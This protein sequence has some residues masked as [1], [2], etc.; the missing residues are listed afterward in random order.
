MKIFKT[1]SEK[2]IKK[3]MPTIEKIVHMDEATSKL[4][5]S[6]LRAKTL[7]FKN[8]YKLGESLEKLLPEAFAVVR[9]AAW[10]VLHMKHYPVQLI[11]GTVL[12]S[13]KIA[14][15]RTGEGKT[16]VST[17]PVYLNALT[18]LGVHVVTVN[19]YLAKRDSEWMGKVY[20]F[21]GLSVGLVVSGM[22]DDLRRAAYACDITYCT[23]T[24]LGFDYLRDNMVSNISLKV[25]RGFN[26]AIVDEIDSVLIDEARTPLIIS[27]F[28]DKT[29]VSY[30]KAND[31]FKTLNGIKIVDAGDEAQSTLTSIVEGN[32][33]PYAKYAE[34]DFVAE[35]KNHNA[36]LTDRG[37]KK[38]EDYYN[39]H[40]VSDPKYSEANFFVS[41]AL[42]A[43]TLYKKDVDYVINQDGE[44]VIVDLGTGRLMPG[45]RFSNGI[46]QGLEAKENV[47][48]RA[49]TVTLATIT[50]QNFFRKYPKLSGM[51]GTAMTEKD[52]FDSIYNLP[53]VE[54]PTNKPIQRVDMPD[55]VYSTNRAKLQAVVNEV[56][57]I[58]STG[59]P[60][61]IGTSSIE[62]SDELHKWLAREKIPHSILNAKH[63]EKEAEI[64]AQAGRYGAIT[65]S[66]NMAGRGTDIILGGNAE[67]M[68]LKFFRDNQYDPSLIAEMTEY[69]ETADENIL[70]ARAAF[71]NKVDE[72][73]ASLADETQ[74]VLSAGGLYVIGTERH[75]SRRIDNQLRG[76]SGR[77]GDVGTSVFFLSLEDDLMRLFGTERVAMIMKNNLPEN[78]PI[79]AK[80]ISTAIQIAQQN[81]ESS[82]FA[83]RRRTLEY[84]TV[85]AIVRDSIYK[86]RNEILTTDNFSG[87]YKS[88]CQKYVDWLFYSAENR[89]FISSDEC[90][91]VQEKLDRE[92]F[93]LV[94]FWREDKN[95]ADIPIEEM[96]N[97]CCNGL[98]DMIMN[99]LN[100]IRDGAADEI[101]VQRKIL[102]QITD[103]F[104][105]EQ[106]E[107]MDDIKSGSYLK[108]LAHGDAYLAYKQDVY[109]SFVEMQ[110]DVS[111]CIIKNFA[112]ILIGSCEK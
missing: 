52:E 85:N 66:T 107:I 12:H 14:E 48:I 34:Y 2:E 46:H 23:N 96:K 73:K 41:V 51:T 98:Y 91:Q 105:K 95:F 54:I 22:K 38:M 89:K 71:K 15:M 79:D 42:K 33:D 1:Y 18:G 70:A 53:I 17:L 68:A 55:R 99:S 25:Q 4:S 78:E 101:D 19:D 36:I 75:E 9:E 80:I 65:I 11:G 28:S 97:R 7:E 32:E 61:L 81:I 13:G 37:I 30:I 86:Q 111:E 109:D 45:R 88:V 39:L 43:N 76:R 93:M 94:D 90:V 59:Q 8:R 44:I 27:G 21:L 29:D 57:L 104:W 108:S 16:L 56:K 110:K 26:Y 63:H 112:F 72:I 40:D 67:Y 20:K 24:E 49:E 74:K 106:M 92:F 103:R 64:I 50:Y 10:R 82:N 3:I 58:H 6:E 77:Q 31:F 83:Q 62:K 102:L 69:S 5:D 47:A 100:V 84:D 60:I 35:E 87:Y